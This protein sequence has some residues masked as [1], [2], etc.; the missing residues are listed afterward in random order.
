[1]FNAG[2]FIWPTNACPCHARPRNDSC[3]HGTALLCREL[4]PGLRPEQCGLPCAPPAR[5][6]C[7]ENVTIQR[8]FAT[9]VPSRPAVKTKEV[10]IKSCNI[11][12]CMFPTMTIPT[13]KPVLS[14]E[15]MGVC[16]HRRTVVLR[17]GL[18][19]FQ[20]N[21]TDRDDHYICTHYLWGTK[22]SISKTVMSDQRSWTYAHTS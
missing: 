9:I 12:A 17:Y 20:P 14:S 3:Y 2:F 22:P 5:A 21:N 1:M 4:S 8:Q 13:T 7:E 6:Q 18:T 16:M 11:R 15:K 10:N 19:V